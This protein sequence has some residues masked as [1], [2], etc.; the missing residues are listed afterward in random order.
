MQLFK[1]Y[2]APIAL[3][4]TASA[5]SLPAAADWTKEYP[6][7]TIGATVTENQAATEARFRPLGDYFQEKFG[8]EMRVQ[9]ASDYAA[10]VQALT[11][12]HIQLA[13]LG[14]S[15]YAAGYIDSEGGIEPVAVPAEL[16]GSLGYHSVLIVRSDSPYQK[17]EDLKG[18]SLAWADPN[19]TSGYLVPMVSL[20]SNGIEPKEFFGETVFSGGHEQ[21]V[22]GVLNGTL[23]SAFTWT[24]KDDNTGQLR[25]MMDRDMLKREDVRVVWESPLIPN[26]L[27]AVPSDLPADMKKDLEEFFLN[28]HKE[29]PELAD[30][31]ASGR[32]SG[33]VVA[34]HDMY[35]PVVEAVQ[36]LR[37]S[38]RQR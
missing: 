14:G 29:R 35:S 5:V 8:V 23:D 9:Q 32:T 34:T 4:I 28:L 15:S 31:A 6:V 25:M 13:R 27:Y 2:L 22:I 1:S 10:V 38:R 36:E 37:N 17:L 21:S 30:A 16:D 19:S 18:K 7:V 3:A 12:G 20:R 11:A 24:S 33:F 26:P